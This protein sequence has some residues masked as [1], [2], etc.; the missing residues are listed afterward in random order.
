MS[1]SR[2]LVSGGPLDRARRDLDLFVRQHRLEAK[3]A[4]LGRDTLGGAVR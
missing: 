4:K 2:S 3:L 1:G